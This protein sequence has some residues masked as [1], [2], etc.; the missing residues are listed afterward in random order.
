MD[1]VKKFDHMKIGLCVVVCAIIFYGGY[2]TAESIVPKVLFL[3]K[4]GDTKAYAK[5]DLKTH[6]IVNVKDGKDPGVYIAFPL[7]S[8]QE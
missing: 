2:K 5:L 4:D 6:R 1:E 7:Y 3:Q 8:E